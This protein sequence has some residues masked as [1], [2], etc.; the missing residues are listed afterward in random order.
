MILIVE[1]DA[2]NAAA[3]RA[4]LEDEGYDVSRA[5]DGVDALRMLHEGARPRL[6]ILD[7]MMPNLD[8]LQLAEA[9]RSDTAF[10]AIPLLLLTANGRAAA[11]QEGVRNVDQV[12]SKP[13]QLTELLDLVERHYQH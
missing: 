3:I 11:E 6:M 4:V 7:F 13:I 5:C 12:L 1:D 8:G 2:D 9:V 10:A